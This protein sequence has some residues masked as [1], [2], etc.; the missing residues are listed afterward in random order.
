MRKKGL[1]AWIREIIQGFLTDRKTSL[2]F[3]GQSS[4]VIHTET[5]IPQGS[6]L[7]PILFLIFITPLIEQT[8]SENLPQASL[9]FVD[10]TNLVVWSPSAQRNCRTLEEIHKTCL[11]W[12]KRSGASFAPDKYQLIHLTRRRRADTSACINIP[13]FD[14]KP[15]KSLKILGVWIDPKLSWKEHIQKAAEKGAKQFSA[16]SRI[17]GSTWGLSFD[18]ARLL[19]T[20]TVRSSITHG[21]PAWALGDEGSGLPAKVTKPLVEIQ[22]QCLRL[23]TG[24]FKRAAGAALEQET[25]IPPIPLY[26][27]NLAREQAHS[28]RTADAARYITNRTSQVL[29]KGQQRRR[30]QI[31]GWKTPRQKAIQQVQV[32]QQVE[33]EPWL[34]RQWKRMFAKLARGRTHAVWDTSN[35]TTGQELRAGLNRSE[36]SILTQLRT[37]NIGLNHY[38]AKRKVPGILP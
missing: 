14:S 29:L 13:R 31:Q 26:T 32:Y 19:Y 25:Q 33:R 21:A 2:L 34:K 36:A 23:V 3:D 9:G 8:N 15:Q 28:T 18:K 35:N 6:P 20:S 1:P 24:A 30:N 10:D 16:L 4:P 22:H 27:L 7:S 37:G 12:A 17:T 11:T 38:L 5:G